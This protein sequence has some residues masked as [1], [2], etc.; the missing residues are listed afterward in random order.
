MRRRTGLSRSGPAKLGSYAELES[1]TNALLESV[2][3]PQK[4]AAAAKK[5]KGV[6]S[7]S[8]KKKS[9]GRRSKKKRRSKKGGSAA[10]KREVL[11]RERGDDRP[12]ASRDDGA[13]DALSARRRQ[14]GLPARSHFAS[15]V[16]V[17]DYD[18]EDERPRSARSEDAGDLKRERERVAVFDEAAQR[19]FKFGAE[20]TRVASGVDSFVPE[21]GMSQRALDGERERVGAA[22][23]TVETKAT[24]AEELE[25]TRKRL[26]DKMESDAAR[27]R[28]TRQ[29]GGHAAATSIQAQ[30][31]GRL[32]RD[33]ASGAAKEASPLPAPPL[34][35]SESAGFVFDDDEELDSLVNGAGEPRNPDSPFDGTVALPLAP[36]FGAERGAGRDGGEGLSLPAVAA[37]SPR[38]I[39]TQ[40]VA[41]DPRFVKQ[42]RAALRSG[43]PKAQTL[44]P[45]SF[46]SASQRIFLP[47]GHASQSALR[48]TVRQA[49]G[50][51][52]FDSVATLL[53]EPPPAEAAAAKRRAAAAA[54]QGDGSEW[55]RA[56][57]TLGRT[58][59]DGRPMAAASLRRSR[60]TRSESPTSPRSPK[61]KA[62]AAAGLA[63]RDVSH[64]SFQSTE[65]V[66]GD[67]PAGGGAKGGSATPLLGS[68]KMWEGKEICF[69]CWS[70]G[71]GMTCRLHLEADPEAALLTGE[72][73]VLVCDNWELDVMRKR[74][75]CLRRDLFSTSPPLSFFVPKRVA[76]PDIG[77]A[78]PPPSSP[79]DA[80]APS[81]SPPLSPSQLP[82]GGAPGSVCED[83]LVAALEQ[84]AETLSD[85]DGI[86]APDVP[87]GD[88]VDGRAEPQIQRPDALEQVGAVIHRGRPH[89]PVTEAAE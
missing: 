61:A 89:V 68:A 59:D 41:D 2:L 13:D 23:L 1:E 52:R 36:I 37:P 29:L 9:G 79:T 72:K 47:D 38:H 28:Y 69:A 84:R 4:A 14:R 71:A 88:G 15:S 81:F 66:G 43:A 34:A 78:P 49:L 63:I 16:E 21:T 74:C 54:S 10:E 62:T 82:L 40:W 12:R 83:E 75:V 31:R 44:D 53:A 73:S 55:M 22:V 45:D 87:R 18:D 50:R 58:G 76:T 24:E 57:S 26:G 48:A 46:T 25:R 20:V 56:S 5:S 85:R 19:D 33:A 27:T 7:A 8:T 70:A 32:E 35:G 39:Q 51:N 60:K 30:L 65:Q 6:M 80:H 42:A 3:R 77:A 11:S 64:P 17:L 86:E 67:S